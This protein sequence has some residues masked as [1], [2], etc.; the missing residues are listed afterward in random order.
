MFPNPSPINRDREQ[1]QR[2]FGL[3]LTS[4]IDRLNRITLHGMMQ[5]VQINTARRNQ[6]LCDAKRHFILVFIDS[7]IAVAVSSRVLQRRCVISVSYTS[8]ISGLAWGLAI[9]VRYKRDDKCVEN[10]S[11]TQLYW[12]LFC[13]C[14]TTCVVL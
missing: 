8:G 4:T 12:K 7:I 9:V 6:H 13:I 3:H 1:I 14:E 5:R 2:I 11:F 10:R